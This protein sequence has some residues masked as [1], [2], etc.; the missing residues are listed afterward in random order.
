MSNFIQII[1]DSTTGKNA[2]LLPSARTGS[3]FTDSK[4]DDVVCIQ[5]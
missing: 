4:V 5:V 2:V 1:E 3:H